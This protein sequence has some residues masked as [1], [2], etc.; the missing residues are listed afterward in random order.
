MCIDN[1]VCA[2]QAAIDACDSL[3]DGAACSAGSVGEGYCSH[4]AC[5]P[6]ACGDGQLTGTEV[7]DGDLISKSCAD[8]NYYYG[9]TACT[10]S[11]ELDFSGCSGRCGDGTVQ[12]DQGED[13]D[14]Q[15][16]EFDCTDVGY[17]YGALACRNCTA[18]PIHS[19]EQFG[20]RKVGVALGY[21][22]KLVGDAGMYAF[23]AGTGAIE[24]HDSAGVTRHG[25]PGYVALDARA[26]DVLA[27]TASTV[28]LYHAGT[29][30]T[31]GGPTT[32][33][34]AIAEATLAADGTPFVLLTGGGACEIASYM[35]GTWNPVAAPSGCSNLTALAADNY[36]IAVNDSTVRWTWPGCGA[37]GC[38]CGR[39]YPVTAT[40]FAIVPV[41]ANLLAYSYSSQVIHEDVVPTCGSGPSATVLGSVPYGGP[42]PSLRVRDGEVFMLVNNAF[43]SAVYRAASGGVELLDGPPA[44]TGQQANLWITRDRVVY[45][46][47]DGQLY[48]LNDLAKT[49]RPAPSEPQATTTGMQI[50]IAGDGTIVECGT[51]L[52]VSAATPSAYNP[53]VSL[54]CAGPVTP[55]CDAL[56]A[57][58]ASAIFLSTDL[59]GLQYWDG[60]TLVPQ[61]DTGIAIAGV[62]SLAGVSDAVV[63]VTKNGDVYAGKPGAW[64][65][66]PKVPSCVAQV[67]GVAPDFTQY[68]GGNCGT[69]AVIWRFDAGTS[70]WQEVFRDM[71]AKGILSLSIAGDGTVFAAEGSRIVIG[72]ATWTGYDGVGVVVA[73]V[74]ANDAWATNAAPANRIMHWDGTR[75]TP[76]AFDPAYFVTIAAS[77]SDVI[78]FGPLNSAI[79]QP[80]WRSLLRLP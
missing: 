47:G 45:G 70:K 1:A 25:S 26:G 52:F 15:P 28:E 53:L 2:T 35:G 64:A 29:W 48:R 41:G 11:C 59:G 74:S 58:N 42:P 46:V 71:T 77:A 65:L 3:A 68:V 56:Y 44:L 20:W 8:L 50:A 75:W 61:Q 67:A 14:G 32:S 79:P 73:A 43:A 63:A 39:P 60:A 76:V 51:Q 36:A 72:S 19:C 27:A 13:C 37:V 17:D 57:Q 31:L 49:H 54:G 23:V 5:V 9:T 12:A 4:G 6:N 7:C 24:V 69:D 66:L 18:D 16:P 10:A 40:P 30:T 34:A 80:V 38:E 33:G 55:C 22:S 78:A 21:S 62:T